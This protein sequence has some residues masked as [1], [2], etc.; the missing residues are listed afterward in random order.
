MNRTHFTLL[1]FAGIV[2]A[3]VLGTSAMADNWP[4]WRG[5][6][7]NGIAATGEYPTSW[8]A[9]ENVAW[10]I[11]LDGRGASTPVVWE[12]NIILTM[13]RGGKNILV[14]F[15]RSGKQNWELEVGTEKASG[16]NPSC[17]TDGKLVFAY[18]K[19]G[20]LV[21]A[22]LQGNLK[23]HHNVQEMFGEDTLWWDLGS[24]PIL[25]KAHVI[26]TVMQS[27]PSYLAAFDKASG[28]SAWKI[29]RNL[30]APEEAAQAYSTPVVEMVD[31]Q[32]RIYVLGADHATGHD[33]ATGKELWRVGGLNPTQHQYFRSISGPVLVGNMLIA[34]YA[35]GGSVT[36]I[37]LGGGGDVTKT[38]VAWTA[39]EVGSDVPTPTFLGDRIFICR[40]N[41]GEKGSLA[42]LNLKSGE[43]V[44][45]VLLEKNRNGFSA[46]PTLAGSHLYVTREDGTTFVVDVSD[47]AKV[48]ATNSLA[49]E[50]TVAT[51]VLVDGQIL[52]RTYEHLYCIGK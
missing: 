34:P 32:E 25:T 30:G 1:L 28:K 14:S 38:H 35:R 52:L 15:D 7:S 18:F 23:W 5:P 44:D 39:L 40:D 6:T 12:N 48:V 51:P 50:F 42:T 21:A 16:S 9:T 11:K 24:S 20:D 29:D 33:A 19:S 17:V 4:G 49:D 31:G 8:S 36:G 22:D 45:E 47:K 37:R 27:G 13:G 46:S 2:S 41:G 3:T 43:I 10:K 26:I